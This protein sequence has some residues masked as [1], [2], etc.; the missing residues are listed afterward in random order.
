MSFH[1]FFKGKVFGFCVMIATEMLKITLHSVLH[2]SFSVSLYL[3]MFLF[4][5]LICEYFFVLLSLD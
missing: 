1:L 5:V 2:F 3:V 4:C